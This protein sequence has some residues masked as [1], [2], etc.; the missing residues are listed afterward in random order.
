MPSQI[1]IS[2]SCSGLKGGTSNS[3]NAAPP[4][5][6]GKGAAFIA[7]G[8]GPAQAEKIKIVIKNISKRFVFKESPL[9]KAYNISRGFRQPCAEKFTIILVLQSKY[10]CEA[11]GGTL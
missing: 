7:S 1:S 5:D 2:V 10:A 8:E 6:A 11:V 9:F 4:G 3:E